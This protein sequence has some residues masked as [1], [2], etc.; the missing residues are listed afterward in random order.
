MVNIQYKNTVHGVN[1]Y[2]DKDSKIAKRI[3]SS[4]EGE[5]LSDDATNILEEAES[6]FDSELFWSDYKVTPKTLILLFQ[7]L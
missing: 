2:I 1:V 5:D 7:D 6:K 3:I 4:A